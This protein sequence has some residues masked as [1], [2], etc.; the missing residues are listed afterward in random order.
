VGLKSSFQLFG[1]F[2]GLSIYLG[3][4]TLQIKFINDHFVDKTILFF[5]NLECSPATNLCIV[6]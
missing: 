4:G 1:K 5:S 6:C 2:C 3:N